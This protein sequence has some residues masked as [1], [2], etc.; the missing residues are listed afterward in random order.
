MRRWAHAAGAQ[1]AGGGAETQRQR[2]SGERAAE[3]RCTTTSASDGGVATGAHASNAAAS[4]GHGAS[5][6]LWARA[7]RWR[8]RLASTRR[9]S[10]CAE[11]QHACSGTR[12]E[13]DGG[14]LVASAE[15]RAS[16]VHEQGTTTRYIGSSSSSPNRSTR[17]SRLSFF[18][19]VWSLAIIGNAEFVPS[20]VHGGRLNGAGSELLG[21]C[22]PKS[23]GLRATTKD[24]V[25]AGGMATGM[26]DAMDCVACCRFGFDDEHSPKQ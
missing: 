26:E 15:Q 6:W 3:A 8:Q 11:E 2:P 21:R 16:I 25:R 20:K 7:A 12:D 1:R 4:H 22:K 5:A 9:H 17:S 19:F 14:A 23:T 24:H 18:L 13:R 10:G